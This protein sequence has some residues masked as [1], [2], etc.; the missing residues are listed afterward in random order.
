M[1]FFIWV[2]SPSVCIAYGVTRMVYRLI[3]WNYWEREGETPRVY[4]SEKHS[5]DEVRRWKQKARTWLERK[6]ESWHVGRTKEKKLVNS[7]TVCSTTCDI[8]P[9]SFNC[10]AVWCTPKL[11][12]KTN[13]RMN[14]T[15]LR[16]CSLLWK[17]EAG[18]SPERGRLLITAPCTYI[19]KCS[20]GIRI[21]GI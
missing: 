11:N 12:W 8:T 20:L 21:P 15:E 16:G 17:L 1:A 13:F 7:R 5:A 10:E 4:G 14:Y 6:D 3:S 2:S 19:L 18:W 9:S